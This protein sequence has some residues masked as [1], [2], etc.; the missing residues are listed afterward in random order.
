MQDLPRCFLC[1]P[2]R[3]ASSKVG[4]ARGDPRGEDSHCGEFWVHAYAPAGH[5]LSIST[6]YPSL[7]K[8]LYT[9]S[10]NLYILK[11]QGPLRQISSI[12]HTGL[13]KSWLWCHRVDISN[14]QLLHLGCF[15]YIACAGSTATA[16]AVRVSKPLLAHTNVFYSAAGPSQRGFHNI[17]S[18]RG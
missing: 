3:S 2:T 11:R 4:L 18:I 17:I 13:L 7:T 12:I 9:I 8:S 15:I 1:D 16:T 5:A 14:T 10:I 6:S